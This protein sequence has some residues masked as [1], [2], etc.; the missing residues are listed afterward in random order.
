MPKTPLFPIPSRNFW[1]G[2]RV[3]VTGNT[4]FKGGWLSLWLARLGA[5]VTGV[6]LNPES[7]PNLFELAN[8]HRMTA[9]NNIVD[10]RDAY[11]LDKIVKYAQPEI[12]LHLAAQALVVPA[13]EDPLG[14]FTTNVQGTANLLNALRGLDCV[15]V[16]VM[17]TTDKVY[18]NPEDGYPF[19]ETDPLGGHD[20][21]SASKAATE[22]IISCYYKSF[23][24]KQGVAVASA[25][26]GNVIGGGDWSKHRLIPDAIR[27][28]G[29]GEV[30]SVRYP[31]ATRPWQHVLEP[32]AGY[33]R[34]SECLWRDPSLAGPYNFG[35]YSNEFA[36][37]YDVL[38]IACKDF[39]KG[40]IK[41]SETEANFHEA[42]RLSLE[43]TKANNLLNVTPRWGLKESIRRT[44]HWYRQYLDGSDALSL[45]NNDF[46]AFENVHQK[47]A[48]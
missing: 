36:K 23:L 13:Y 11:T 2:K 29:V 48:T 43:I 22:L 5:E 25:R 24:Q 16:A 47:N 42:L 10:I 39:G 15:R 8:V 14:T 19:R 6:G 45:C 18:D 33:L 21:Y 37:V 20:P 7:D 31:Q 4:G 38:K 44:M 1:T 40:A 34:L 46:K 32:L 28:W 27:T 41:I 26:A 17:V 35:P 30:L 12:V 3:L 9:S